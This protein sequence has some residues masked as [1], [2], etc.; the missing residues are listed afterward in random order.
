M[1]KSALR[2]ATCTLALAAGTAMATPALLSTFDTGA[3][4]WSVGSS[5]GA[6]GVTDFFWDASGGHPGG[7]VRAR[8][9]GDQGGWWFLSPL[10]W[11]GD[12]SGYLG[13]SVRFDVYAIGGQSQELNP[14][15]E[16][17]VL[18]L[19]DGG[20]LRARAGA[21]ALLDQWIAVDMPLVA[22]NFNLT[23]SQYASFD[24]ALAHVVQL[25][26]PGDFVYR[27]DDLTRLDNVRV[28]AAP[29][30]GTLALLAAAAVAGLASRRRQRAVRP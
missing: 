22:E 24:E 6:Q 8:D 4:G 20:R 9:I 26:I 30:P 13:G 7:H 25:V 29:V 28:S 17:F 15:F 14:P 19:E 5:Q 27:Q 12:W 1:L 16:A 23:N 11:G 10:A 2:L 18:V 21:G 3:E